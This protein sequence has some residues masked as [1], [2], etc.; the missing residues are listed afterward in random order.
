MSN[1]PV[2]Y[3]LAQA[4]FNPVAAMSRY[5]DQIQDRLRREGYPL[6]ELQQVTHLEVQAPGQAQPAEP[7]ITHTLSWLITR[8]DRTAGFILAPS[9]I[10]Y[11]T[12][13]YETNNEFIPALLRGLAAVH[14]AAV[15]DHISRLGLRYLDAVLPRAHEDVEQYLVGGLH[16]IEFDAVRRYMLTESVFGTQTRP[17]VPTGTLVT[18]VHRM[19]APLGFPPDMQPNGL[20]VSPKFEAKEPRPHAVIDTDHFVEGRMPIDMDQLGEQLRS[21]HAAI[22]SAFDA[23]TTDHA[24]SAWA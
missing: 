15:L 1:A 2:Y 16:G 7:R 21:L 22:K 24:R 20:V 10:T 8:S 9:S 11:H 4:H 12:T 13:H 14:E 3:A 5:V 6:F 17:L 18:R 19:T 23:I